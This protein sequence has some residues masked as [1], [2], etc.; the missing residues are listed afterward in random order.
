MSFDKQTQTTILKSTKAGGVCI[1]E[2]AFHVAQDDLPFGGVGE[3]G[4]GHYHGHEGFLA[5]SKAKPIFSRGK[6]SL[7]SII[8]P[9]Y[10]TRI[11]QLIYKLFIR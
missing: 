10:N 2:A 6:F 9:P 5:L 4:I 11:H 8:S 3:S 1:N 7:G